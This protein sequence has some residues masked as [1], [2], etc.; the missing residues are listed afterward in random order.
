MGE[1]FLKLIHLLFIFVGVV[2]FVQHPIEEVILILQHSFVIRFSGEDV[3]LVFTNSWIE[4]R[5]RGCYM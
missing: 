1:L 5:E 4:Q 2:L 3:A